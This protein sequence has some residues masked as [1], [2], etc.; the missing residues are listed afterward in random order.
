MEGAEPLTLD[1]WADRFATLNPGS[2]EGLGSARAWLRFVEQA[3]AIA[4]DV[5]LDSYSDL[6]RRLGEGFGW[7]CCFA[8]FYSQQQPQ[9]A[10]QF[11]SSLS[12]MVW[13]KYPGV[14][15]RCTHDFT[16][17]QVESEGYLACRCLSIPNV[18]EGEKAV[19]AARLEVAR[20]RKLRPNSPDNWAK[21]IGAVYGPNHRQLSLS[22]LCLHFFEEVG[23]VAEGLRDLEAIGP[24]ADSAERRGKIHALEDEI[25]DV[26]SWIFG[27]LNKVEQILLQGQGY[28]RTAARLEL[29][30]IETTDLL[31][32]TLDQWEAK[33]VP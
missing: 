13:R 29:P 24:M 26:F 4:E 5:R 19:R 12:D 32:R 33:E 8:R 6:I 22:A 17:E 20:T 9:E 23:E 31:A 1:E 15:Y 3:A 30:R 28:Y 14:C 18:S 21:M 11:Q 25:A 7:L 27:M 2:W 16:T 10:F